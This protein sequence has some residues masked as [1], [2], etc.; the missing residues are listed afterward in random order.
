MRKALLMA[1]ILFICSVF[2]L[3][4]S[5]VVGT[6]D[7]IASVDQDYPFTLKIVEKDGELSGTAETSYGEGGPVEGIN[8]EGDTLTFSINTNAAG[9]VDFTATVDGDTMKGTLESWD[10]GGEFSARR[11]E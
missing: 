7:C 9:K 5:P 2:A 6:W 3:A 10:F 4:A 1:A 8:L 11:Q